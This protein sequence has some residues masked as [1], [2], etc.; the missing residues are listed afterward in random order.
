MNWRSEFWEPSITYFLILML[1]R[2]VRTE[3]VNSAK[4][5]PIT[6]FYTNASIFNIIHLHSL[7]LDF[8]R[9]RKTLICSDTSIEHGLEASFRRT[10]GSVSKNPSNGSCSKNLSILNRIDVL[11]PIRDYFGC[12]NKQ[13]SGI[14]IEWT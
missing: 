7:I 10:L 13:L 8:N 3:Q 9:W 12:R 5:S 2:Y 6:Y 4:Q 14:G 11:R 1:I